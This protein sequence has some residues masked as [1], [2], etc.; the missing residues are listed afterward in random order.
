MK[1]PQ[2]QLRVWTGKK[3]GQFIF[4]NEKKPL[5]SRLIVNS[6]DS[7]YNEILRIWMESNRSEKK[8]HEIF[9]EF[10][11]LNL[12]SES[13]MSNWHRTINSFLYFKGNHEGFHWFRIFLSV[14]CSRFQCKCSNLLYQRFTWL[15]SFW[16]S[17]CYSFRETHQNG[18]IPDPF[19]WVSWKR[20]R[21]AIF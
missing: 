20:Y 17:S 4:A 21:L 13:P 11:F 12:P 1:K 6:G 19:V 18:T 3:F 9:F 5:C 8:P 10:H 7:N 16:S 15:A 2:R 14:L